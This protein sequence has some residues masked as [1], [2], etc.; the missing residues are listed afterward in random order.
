MK[1]KILKKP[2]VSRRVERFLIGSLTLA[3]TPNFFIEHMRSKLRMDP[4]FCGGISAT[5]RSILF[6][7]TEEH[8]S[9]KTGA[10]A[11]A[12]AGSSASSYSSTPPLTFMNV[13]MK[14]KATSDALQELSNVRP[15]MMPSPSNLPL[16]LIL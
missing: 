14:M 2:S 11:G 8:F 10:G 7:G 12:G 4:D 15:M 5:A 1:L 13:A 6:N 3:V 16:I 9:A